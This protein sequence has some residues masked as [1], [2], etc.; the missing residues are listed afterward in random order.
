ML[1]HNTRSSDTST[2]LPPPLP[3]QAGW[4]ELGGKGAYIHLSLIA[5][6]G[7]S[8][9]RTGHPIWSHRAETS[10]T[11]LAAPGDR[12]EECPRLP[13]I[14][15]RAAAAPQERVQARDCIAGFSSRRRFC[16]SRW[17]LS[18]AVSRAMTGP[19]SGDPTLA[20]RFR[21]VSEADSTRP[22]T[23][24]SR[25]CVDALLPDPKSR[26]LVPTLRHR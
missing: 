4:E 17:P 5:Y 23:A 13:P 7:R 20:H 24:L 19:G 8:D 22:T 14:P 12:S 25:F 26:D 10:L 18:H 1:G 9:A 11:C 16:S 15:H 21:V 3:L 6:A 2:L